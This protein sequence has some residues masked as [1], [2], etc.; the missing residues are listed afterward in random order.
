MNSVL[1]QRCSKTALNPKSDIETTSNMY[2]SVHI[3]HSRG[4]IEPPF[5]MRNSQTSVC[6]PSFSGCSNLAT[7]RQRCSILPSFCSTCSVPEETWRLPS[8]CRPAKALGRRFCTFFVLFSMPV[9][10]TSCSSCSDS[11]SFHH[12]STI[13]FFV[14]GLPAPS[15]LLLAE[16]ALIFLLSNLNKWLR[17]FLGRKTHILKYLQPH[18]FKR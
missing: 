16:V 10:A 6:F 11:A 18:F 8:K 14:F 7:S 9:L 15:L 12:F 1:R 3:R 13:R 4:R 17:Y 2:E 5:P